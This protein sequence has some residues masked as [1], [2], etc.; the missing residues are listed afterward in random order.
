MKQKTWTDLLG[1]FGDYGQRGERVSVFER[2][3]CATV[4]G[5]FYRVL[6]TFPSGTDARA[7]MQ[8]WQAGR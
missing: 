7:A 6:W 5:V 4:D 3:L 2:D 8:Y 1:A